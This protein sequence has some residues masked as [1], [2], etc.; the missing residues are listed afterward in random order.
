M[1]EGRKVLQMLDYSDDGGVIDV[2]VCIA[3]EPASA[4]LYRFG[5]SPMDLI[6]KTRGG[7]IEFES[8]SFRRHAALVIPQELG[9]D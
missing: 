7:H 5:E 6:G 3:S 1:I 9:K 2:S 4:A 8:F